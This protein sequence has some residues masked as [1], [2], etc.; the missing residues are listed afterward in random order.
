MELND[1]VAAPSMTAQAI[2]AFSP[3]QAK[4]SV[5]VSS[6]RE[7]TLP[8]PSDRK[9]AALVASKRKELKAT[10]VSIENLR[11]E[12]TKPLLDGQR[13]IKAVADELSKAIAPEE[14]RL[15]LLE[16]DAKEWV[17]QEKAR[18]ARE[19]QELVD[20]RVK[21][22]QHLGQHLAPSVAA[23]MPDSLWETML[24]DATESHDIAKAE[25][26][27]MEARR[28]AKLAAEREKREAAEAKASKQAAIAARVSI[29]SQCGVHLS[30]EEALSFTQEEWDVY[31]QNLRA[32]T[33]DR[34]A[35]QEAAKDAEVAANM[36]E[37]PVAVRRVPTGDPLVSS[38]NPDT[39]AIREPIFLEI[40]SALNLALA[41][42]KNK[43]FDCARASISACLEDVTGVVYW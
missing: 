41:L 39:Q 18:K 19:L 33:K 38:A 35:R 24:A 26:K 42:S 7:I 22:L 40:I 32:S 2:K 31:C 6:A 29:A 15:S 17:Q 36:E 30:A 5:L 28:E 9:Q 4:L 3:T 21:T 13:E 8:D 37:H 43:G 10:R 1:D 34:G 11:K 14:S 20:F 27:A 16:N 25:A 12:L 23:D